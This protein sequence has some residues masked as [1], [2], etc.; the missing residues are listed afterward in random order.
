MKTA[1]EIRQNV[2]SAQLSFKGWPTLKYAVIFG[3]TLAAY[4]AG[5]LTINAVSGDARTPVVLVAVFFLPVVARAWMQL[6]WQVRED[7]RGRVRLN[8]RARAF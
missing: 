4:V 7:L 6:Y 5:L 8:C 3:I 2:E 1:N